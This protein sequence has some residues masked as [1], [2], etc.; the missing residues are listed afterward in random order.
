MWED[1]WCKFHADEFRK[2]SVISWFKFGVDIQYHAAV[3]PAAKWKCWLKQSII[4]LEVQTVTWE[5]SSFSSCFWFSGLRALD[6]LMGGCR[7]WGGMWHC[8][9]LLFLYFAALFMQTSYCN[10]ALYC[11][12]FSVKLFISTQRRV[13]ATFSPFYVGGKWD[14]VTHCNKLSCFSNLE[15]IIW[16]FFSLLKPIWDIT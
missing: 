2:I 11:L 9:L 10:C 3:K 12:I 15:K 14:M 4:R 5:A 1:P 6:F 7:L 8:L 16:L 13:C